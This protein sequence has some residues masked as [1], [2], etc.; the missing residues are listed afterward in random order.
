[1]G[2]LEDSAIEQ[3][4]A[5]SSSSSSATPATRTIQSRATEDNMRATED[6]MGVSEIA[7]VFAE[8]DGTDAPMEDDSS[9]AGMDRMLL[10]LTADEEV[11]KRRPGMT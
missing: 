10:S 9:Q 1:M 5:S 2:I 11:S 3:E 7:E 6:N 4:P 8:H